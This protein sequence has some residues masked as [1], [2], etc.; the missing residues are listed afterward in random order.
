[1]WQAARAMGTGVAGAAAL[2]AVAV[3][4]LPGLPPP[5]AASAVACHHLSGPFWTRGS[6]VYGAHGQR[7]VPYG[8]NLTPVRAGA[9]GAYSVAGQIA[10]ENAAATFWCVNTVR[11]GVSQADLLTGRTVNEAYLSAIAALV[12]HAGAAGLDTVLSLGGPAHPLG[13][14]SLPQSSTLAAWKVLAG[15][16]RGDPQ[17]IFDLF[18]EPTGPWPLWRNGGTADGVTYYGMQY[19]AQFIRRQGAR[20]LLWI[21]GNNRAGNLTGIPAYHL[22]GTGPLMYDEHRPPA[23]HSPASWW[24]WF[25]STITRY[26]VVVGEWA[27]YSRTGAPWACWDDAPTAVGKF[28][29]YLAGLRVGLVAYD[30]ARPRLLESASLTDP[31]HIRANWR[32]ASGLNEG[33][34]HQV[35][36][37]FTRHNKITA[38][39]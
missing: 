22:T 38:G 16:F 30:L 3:C 31:N 2:T 9:T 11:A 37:W 26:P 1:M 8:I 4:T 5:V 21:E 32:C 33:A 29:G 18:N 27:D 20:N 10:Q 39:R 6:A 23:P 15:R 35:M 14:P 36:Q 13:T 34:G 17:V 7:Y 24:H 12:G 25:A 19:L 28:L